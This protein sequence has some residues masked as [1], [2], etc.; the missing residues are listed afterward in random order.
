MNM[1]SAQASRPNAMV[2]PD[3]STK[4][5]PRIPLPP[6]P[7][8]C[9]RGT[10]R[11]YEHL[12]SD[13][14]SPSPD[15]GLEFLEAQR[16][17]DDEKP[18][19]NR[20]CLASVTGFF[21]HLH[22]MLV[23]V[24]R[25]PPIETAPLSPV[26]C[27]PQCEP[28]MNMQPAVYSPPKKRY[29][30]LGWYQGGEADDYYRSFKTTPIV[31]YRTTNELPATTSQS[32]ATEEGTGSRAVDIVHAPSPLQF[33]TAKMPARQQIVLSDSFL[34]E[35][36]DMDERVADEA[37]IAVVPVAGQVD[38]EDCFSVGSF[39]DD[40]D[41]DSAEANGN[42][43]VNVPEVIFTERRT[44]L[45]SLD[46]QDDGDVVAGQPD[47]V[48]GAVPLARRGSLL[49]LH[50]K[51][52]I[53]EQTNRDVPSRGAG[54]ASHRDSLF[55]LNS[56]DEP[57]DLDDSEIPQVTYEALHAE[58]FTT[59][60]DGPQQEAVHVVNI[61]RC[62]WQAEIC[63]VYDGSD[64]EYDYY[65]PTYELEAI[66]HPPE[67]NLTIQEP[68]QLNAVGTTVPSQYPPQLSPAS[69]SLASSV[70]LRDRTVGQWET[71]D[72]FRSLSDIGTG[73]LN[74]TYTSALL[75]TPDYDQA[76]LTR[77][78]HL[79]GDAWAEPIDQSLFAGFDASFSHDDKYNP[80]QRRNIVL[81][82][83]TAEAKS[84]ARLQIG[85]GRCHTVA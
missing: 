1:R 75:F 84:D 23:P 36:F 51:D 76:C 42:S 13:T 60:H 22:G 70:V 69:T 18:K 85:R 43:P 24:E 71:D 74:S 54:F 40:N 37:N 34:V 5:F 10:S 6:R 53:D 32:F 14:S 44:S 2:E 67:P 20:S 12:E 15:P 4:V 50:F 49:L 66:P 26:F 11:F 31:D 73:A 19:K 27:Q 25:E 56:E 16:G 38:H 57:A 65:E 77:F 47:T 78:V 28:A 29:R 63:E 21:N 30:P 45:F 46:S 82:N 35:N 59:L 39:D 9:P 68:Q 80:A 7:A 79:W 64:E 52:G 48:P 81:V 83:Q 3:L 58:A 8:N 72:R 41:A 33:A 62:S 17:L 61:R 55:S